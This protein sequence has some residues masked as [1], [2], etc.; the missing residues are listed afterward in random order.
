MSPSAGLWAHLQTALL[1][2]ALLGGLPAR[3]RSRLG[4]RIGAPVLALGAAYLPVA[5]LDL[6]EQL[7]GYCGAL[8]LT[9]LALLA[10]FSGRRLALGGLFS[11][12]E[13]RSLLS[14]AA[15]LGLLLYPMTLGLSHIDPY[16]LGYA[17]P[18]LPL[19]LTLASGAAAWAGMRGVA[20]LGA[21]ILW[22]WL[23]GLGESQNLWDYLLDAWIFLYA[24]PWSST[25]LVRWRLSGS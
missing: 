5:G 9:S 17:H 1:A 22:V 7:Y 13:R 8:S 15:L 24:I 14:G 12:A 2:L 10:D 25:A 18:A 21:A 4:L 11:A 20:W 23:I 19:A 16:A 3:L 6:T